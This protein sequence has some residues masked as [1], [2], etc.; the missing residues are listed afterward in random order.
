MVWGLQSLVGGRHC[1]SS[2]EARQVCRH[3][4]T[5]EMWP[6]SQKLLSQDSGD[7]VKTMAYLPSDC[8]LLV[9]CG[10]CLVL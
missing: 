1:I 9:C 6:P 8:K 4:D 2:G 5:C 7:P 10:R 3:L